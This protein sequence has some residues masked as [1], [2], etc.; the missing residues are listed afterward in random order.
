MTEQNVLL[1]LRTAQVEVTVFQSC[2]L[3]SR[4]VIND[5]KRRR[6]A[7]GKNAQFLDFD[8]DIACRDLFI[9]CAAFPHDTP[10]AQNILRTNGRRFL[11]HSSVGVVVK[12]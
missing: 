11:K 8:F 6:L 12:R 1:Q 2:Q 7:F 10:N 3:G 4:T 9:F 5:L